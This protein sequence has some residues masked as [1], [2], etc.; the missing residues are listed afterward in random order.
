[1]SFFKKLI[2][3]VT[4]ALDETVQKIKTVIKENSQYIDALDKVAKESKEGIEALQNYAIIETP[5]LET[6]I[7]SLADLFLKIEGARANQVD[8]L[9]EKFLG[10]LN[11]LIDDAAK[12]NAEIKD[13]QKAQKDLEKAKKH[14]ESE[15][16]KEAK[17]KPADVSAAEAALKAAE[18]VLRKEEA[19]AKA[20]AEE[21]NKTKLTK[22]KDAIRML[23]EIEQEYHEKVISFLS[24]VKEKAE[25]INIEEESKLDI[26]EEE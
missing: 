8:N 26:P 18:E 23:T 16:K 1:M 2:D 12:L 22:V 4:G 21:F 17:G 24:G 19:E 11:S 13:K 15:K 14:L 6:A 10:P 20:A 5:S 3:T 9:K 7:N 25:A